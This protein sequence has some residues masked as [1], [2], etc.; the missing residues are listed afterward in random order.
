M[1]KAIQAFFIHLFGGITPDECA[2]SNFNSYEIGAFKI[3]RLLKD[4]ADSINGMKA[5][6]WCK[7]MYDEIIKLYH[8]YE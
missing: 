8:N 3:L 6:D 2:N 7:S 4:H 5:D 1:I